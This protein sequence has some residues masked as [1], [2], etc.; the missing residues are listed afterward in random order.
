M[1]RN[2]RDIA[3]LLSEYEIKRFSFYNRF[4]I[5]EFLA[6]QIIKRPLFY[7]LIKDSPNKNLKGKG[8]SQGV[9]SSFFFF[10]FVLLYLKIRKKKGSAFI[11]GHGAYR[12]E[13]NEKDK[14]INNF[15]DHWM[16]FFPRDKAIYIEHRSS[17]KNEGHGVF[18]P[19]I[20]LSFLG[21]VTRLFA[22]VYKKVKK[23]SELINALA[24]DMDSHLLI[25]GIK[26][27]GYADRLRF[28][29]L[30]FQ[31]EY[32]FYRFFF[33]ILKPSIVIVTDSI[34]SGMM[35]AAKKEKIR[36]IENQHGHVDMYKPDYMMDRATVGSLRNQLI[37]PDRI[38]VFGQYFKKSFLE[39]SL[40]FDHEVAPVGN[41]RIDMY[42]E[43]SVRRNPNEISILIPTQWH[44]PEATLLLLNKIVELRLRKRVCIAVKMHPRE[45]KAHVDAYYQFAEANENVRIVGNE[46][47]VYKLFLNSDLVI[48][49]DSTVLYECIAMGVPA[50]TMT[51]NVSV[52]GIHTF[53]S[54]E[55]MVMKAIRVCGL[56][57]IT[58]TI[59]AYFENDLFQKEWS[60]DVQE[61]GAYLYNKNCVYNCQLLLEKLKTC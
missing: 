11:V 20:N 18:L 41:I 9:I 33:K 36:V 58:S 6:W 10:P 37:L 44:V 4:R 59:S 14:Y 13:K 34:A 30:K 48:G 27:E 52:M 55:S 7:S 12:F 51:T 26:K 29:V 54:Q 25:D 45:P 23:R 42:R 3:R 43:M 32:K 60:K 31:V 50:I 22:K 16:N 40:W 39:N 8:N 19:D 15:A 28:I 53:S 38:A 24:E 61:A 56:D 49:F 2:V 1:S 21:S 35:A 47:S 17:N 5:Q 46:E 57:N